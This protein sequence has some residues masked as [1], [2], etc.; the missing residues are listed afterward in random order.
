MK[1]LVIAT[2][3]FIPRWDGVTRFILEIVPA[4]A[5]DYEITIIAPD[6]GHN[7]PI[8]NVKVIKFPVIK[9]SFGDIEFTGLNSGKIRK[10]VQESDIVFVQTLGPI[11]MAAINA[12]KKHRKHIL[13]YIHS[14]EWELATRSVKRFKWLANNIARRVARSY[15]RKCDLL[16]VPAFEV[17]EKHRKLGINTESVLVHLGTDTEKFRPA[18]S[19]KA[20]KK[21]VGLDSTKLHIGFAGRIGREK[22]LLTLYRAF[23]RTEKKHPLARLLVVGKGVKEL[24]NLFSSER[25]IIMPGAVDN[26]EQW[27]QAMDIF[28][29][30]SLTETSSLATMEAMA[31][32]LPVLTT[33]VGFVKEYVHEK[34]NGML[35][36]FKNSLILSMKMNQLIENEALRKKLGANARETIEKNFTWS[37]TIGRIKEILAR[38]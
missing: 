9:V 21:A 33:P 26:V 11:G 3:C 14:L 32:G 31:C 27:L 38:Y 7:K 1:K 8:N 10:I 16:I 34:E 22:D 13:A 23:R 19:K 30:T 4:I 6:F 29:L 18:E 35:F 15:Y 12:G 2:D 24:H 25:N 36:P 20:A 5:D 28:V 17:K 37:Y